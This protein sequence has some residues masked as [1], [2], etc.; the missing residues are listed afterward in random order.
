MVSRLSKCELHACRFGLQNPHPASDLQLSS[1]SGDRTATGWNLTPSYSEAALHFES[2]V[3]D[4][5]VIVWL[6]TMKSI[7]LLIPLNGLNQI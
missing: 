4:D 1:S 2:F 6:I 3:D 5:K 7:T